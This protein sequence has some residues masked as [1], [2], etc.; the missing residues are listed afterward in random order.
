VLNEFDVRGFGGTSDKQYDNNVFSGT[1][2]N[3]VESSE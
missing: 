2:G 3:H 1:K